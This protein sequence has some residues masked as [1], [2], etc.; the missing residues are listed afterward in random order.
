MPPNAVDDPKV[1]LGQLID[2]VIGFVTAQE[3][4]AFEQ[5]A[6]SIGTLMTDAIKTG[7][8]QPESVF[9]AV[10]AVIS[11]GQTLEFGP[12]SIAINGGALTPAVEFGPIGPDQQPGEDR[13]WSIGKIKVGATLNLL[14]PGAQPFQGFAIS[15]ID[16]RLGSGG[17]GATGLVAGLIPDMR[18]M[19]GF[20]LTIGYDANAPQKIIVEGG[21]KIPIQ[22]TLGPLDVQALMIELRKDSLGVGIDLSFQLSVIKITVYELGLR[23]NFITGDGVAPVDVF[24][25]GL[26]LSFDGGGIKLA[27]MFAEVAKANGPP[28]Y[29]GG[30]VVSIVNLF[31]L[32]AIGGY[33]EVDG[34]ASLF[35]FA[36]LVA[37]LGGPPVLFHHRHCRRLRLQPG[38]ATTGTPDGSPVHQGDAR[39]D[40]DGQR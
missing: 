36:S 18:D 33:T 39:R 32:S 15:I 6:Q 2:W 4:G 25:H 34:D 19:P 23:F 31:Q 16:F 37:P 35:L 12:L 24:L 17:G 20:M 13:P 38:A 8:V 27:G 30:A 26:G 1:L 22:Q 28:D 9:A 11:Q 29:V 14:P 3:A 5:V 40:S 7:T 10:A 21:G